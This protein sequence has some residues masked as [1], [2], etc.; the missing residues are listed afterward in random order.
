MKTLFDAIA[1]ENAARSEHEA[2]C[3]AVWETLKS[4]H[5]TVAGQVSLLFPENAAAARW[6]CAP[7]MGDL[8]P[9]EMIAASQVAEV[10]EML[11]RALHGMGG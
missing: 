6:I 3:L 8:S 1:D 5:P 11:T 9:A 10:E 4:T 2:T 7:H